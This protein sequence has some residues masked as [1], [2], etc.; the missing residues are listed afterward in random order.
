MESK[1][2]VEKCIGRGNYGTVYLV[3]SIANKKHYVLKRINYEHMPAKDRDH[4][5]VEVQMLSRLNHPNIVTYKDHME[6]D[7]N[8]FIIM[9]YC[10]DGDLHTKI[11]E[12]SRAGIH[13]S[14]E[15]ILKWFVQMVMALKYVHKER[16]LHRDLKTQNIFLT[17][18]SKVIKLG[19]FGISKVLDGTLDMAK[20]VIGTP[21]YMSPELCENQPYGKASDVWSLGCILYELCVLK[22]AFD[23]TNICGLIF[24][25]LNGSYPP[26]PESYSPELRQLVA[27]MLSRKPEDRPRLE[28]IIEMDFIKPAIQQLQQDIKNS[29]T[30][31][32]CAKRPATTMEQRPQNKTVQQSR[33]PAQER[34]QTCSKDLVLK[35]K[36]DQKAAMVSQRNS[37][38]EAAR[39]EA[40]RQRLKAVNKERQQFLSSMDRPISTPQ[41][42]HVAELPHPP[43]EQEPA[44]GESLEEELPSAD[45]ITDLTLTLSEDQAKSVQEQ[46]DDQAGDEEYDSDFESYSDDFESDNDEEKVACELEKTTSTEG[47]EEPPLTPAIS[48]LVS[49]PLPNAA[50]C[51]K[52]AKF[53][54]ECELK[55][56]TDKL[57]KVYRILM[58]R[59]SGECV[60]NEE[61]KAL[62]AA[63]TDKADEQHFMLVDQLIYCEQQ[64]L[65]GS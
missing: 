3:R 36:E 6:D 18:D 57:N 13:F 50:V 16:I 30:L 33:T 11:K 42:P 29:N 52:A 65:G 51:E 41:S 12:A 49:E 27:N 7:Q 26:I 55:L 58:K 63:V 10:E 8:L 40:H 45:P 28:S 23:A 35:R 22:H 1:Y 46:L 32:N 34:P 54:T 43:A 59:W 37:E 25:I 53:R 24:K 5:A 60:A 48:K 4:V 44:A 61:I 15:Q 14:E 47:R 56:G 38:L 62:L 31:R 39:K 17:R 9:G 21:Y 2:R 64:L 20:T 19:D